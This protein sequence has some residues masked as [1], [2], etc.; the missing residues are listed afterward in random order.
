MRDLK[1]IVWLALL[2]LFV[3][4][5][6]A[7]NEFVSIEGI[8][9]DAETKEPLIFAS[10]YLKGRS[11]GT[12]S[13]E[14]GIFS[15]HLPSASQ[16]DSLVVSSIGYKSYKKPVEDLMGKKDVVI[17]LQTRAT[18]LREVS[19][20]ASKLPKAKDI[21]RK[22]YDRIED[23][24]PIEPFMTEGFF[25]DLQIENGEYVEL[26]EAAVR[27]HYKDYK[28]GYEQVQILQT[29]R[30]YNFRHPKY[31][32]KNYERHNSIVDML[33]DNYVKERFGPVEV[34]GWD[35]KLDSIVTFEDRPVYLISG[36][37]GKVTR[38]LLWI[39]AETY[40]FIKIIM[41]RS[42][43]NGEYYR[44]YLNMTDSLGMIERS[45]KMDLEFRTFNGRMYLKSQREE[46]SYDVI[47]KF[48][49]KIMVNQ[50]AMKELFVNDIITEPERL[51][52]FVASM[53]IN[54]SVEAQ[55]APYAKEFWKH[56][57]MPARTKE[58]SKIIEGLEKRSQENQLK[59][60]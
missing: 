5:A 3:S 15:F 34:K 47:N 30:S 16:S 31:N 49:N 58:G 46:D 57:N 33:E 20:V 25:R 44:R 60:K 27:F 55:A 37:A 59:V 14:E 10:I 52:D 8:V 53:S 24:Y 1:R 32:I 13:N 11:I 21:V 39:D 17:N 2:S 50:I 41:E 4:V 40:G 56:Y 35:Y 6:N 9:R 28:P 18:M 22:A 12:T 7:Q 51:K 42:M 54:K 36:K 43:I 26:L 38:A 19:V 23:N 48:T 29:R 45:F